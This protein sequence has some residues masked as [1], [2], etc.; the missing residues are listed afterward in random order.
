[1]AI[2]HDLKPAAKKN[3]YEIISVLL[4]LLLGGEFS[5]VAK[6][7]LILVLLLCGLRQPDPE[8]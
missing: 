7:K 6:V 1:M 3:S 8:L 2:Q 4:S 5:A